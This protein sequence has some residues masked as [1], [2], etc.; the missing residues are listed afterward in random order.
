VLKEIPKAQKFSSSIFRKADYRNIRRPDPNF[1]NNIAD[2]VI[3]QE[4]VASQLASTSAGWAKASLPQNLHTDFPSLSTVYRNP[5]NHSSNGDS[6]E[7]EPEHESK[8]GKKGKKQV[9]FK[10][11]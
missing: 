1:W 10:F 2:N 5:S 9:L 11:G 4:Q 8:K 7:P 6:R 3:Q